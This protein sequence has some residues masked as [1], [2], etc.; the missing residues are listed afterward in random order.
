MPFSQTEDEGN[1]IVFTR[2]K[3]GVS[4]FILIK[5]LVLA[6]TLIHYLHEISN[7]FAL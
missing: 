7:N 2:M 1:T 6:Y 5:R 4:L 3:T